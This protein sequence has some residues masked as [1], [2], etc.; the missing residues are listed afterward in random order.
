MTDQNKKTLR[1]FQCRD[2]LWA[3]FEQMAQELEC[4]VDYL[5]N[6]AMKQYVRQRGYAQS[7][8]GGPV[9]PAPA[10]R[11]SKAPPPP[12]P[13]GRASAPPP[14]PPSRRAPPPPPP[15]TPPPLAAPPPLAPPAPPAAPPPLAPLAHARAAWW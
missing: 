6:D 3:R 8:A 7:Q 13:P 9:S 5:L 1:S 4:S 14:A 11:S 12:P 10:P 15:G 2:A